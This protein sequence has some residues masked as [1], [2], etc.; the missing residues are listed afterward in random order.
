MLIGINKVKGTDTF[1][2]TSRWI[3]G[4]INGKG[5]GFVL[6]EISAL[7]IEGYIRLNTTIDF[8]L[9]KDFSSTS[10]QDL[11]I[12]A[13]EDENVLDGEPLV[14]F[15]GGSPLGL[16]P[17]GGTSILGDADDDGYRHFIAYLYFPLTQIEYVSIE[18][19]SSGTGQ[20]W[21]IIRLG[22]NA[23]ENVFEAQNR[24]K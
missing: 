12:V 5:N 11:Q 15:L 19:T 9:Y 7:A 8:K 6:N 17:L 4:W 10:F 13:S 16:E 20:G 1:P 24:I 3:S 14:S 22:L 23:I 21:E 2:M 18:I